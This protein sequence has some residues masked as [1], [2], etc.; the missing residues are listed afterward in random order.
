MILIAQNKVGYK[1]LIQLSSDAATQGFYYRPRV[2]LALLEE[3]S[4]GLIC[5]TACIASQFNQFLLEGNFDNAKNHLADLQNIF[6]D[7]FYLELQNHEIPEQKALVEIALDWGKK[8][9]IP[10]VA[11]NDYH[12]VFPEDAHYQDIIFCDQLKSSLD[13]TT[14]MK[15]NQ[16]FYIKT[17]EEMQE[18]LP[19]EDALDNTIKIAESCELSLSKST[20]A[21]PSF[22]KE[23]ARFDALIRQ[24]ITER[25]ELLPDDIYKQRLHDEV[26]IIKDAKL[27]GYFLTVADYI[28]WA[29]RNDVMVGPGR[30][31]VAG[32]L[33]AYVLHIH[34]VDP[35][36]YGLLFSR[37]YNA[38]RKASLP[39]VD[40]DFAESDVS[41]VVNY[42]VEK[43]GND[44]V[45]HIG[46]FQKIAGR[47]A[48]KMV[49]R[50]NRV[51]FDLANEYSSLVDIKKHK[52]LADAA[53]SIAFQ[54][55]YDTDLQFKQI[56]D[57]AK[58]V[59][60]TA[61]S[62]GVHAA[63]IVI[64]SKPIIETIPIRK[65][66]RTDLQVTAWDMEDV[67]S[68]G[69]VKFDFLS[70]GT[71][72][73]MRNCMELAGITDHYTSLPLDD[74]KA[75]ELISTTSNVGVFQLS[76]TGIS[77]LANSMVVRSID[78][79]ATVVALYRP[80]PLESGLDKSYLDRRFGNKRVEYLHAKCEPALKAT[81]GVL[82]FQ[83]QITR[84][85]MDLASFDEEEADEL[86][87]VIGKKLIEKAG[88]K[89][90]LTRIGSN[91]IKKCGENG[92]D[93]RIAEIIWG[94]INKFAGYA[95]NKAH[96]TS[97]ALLTYYTAY[98]KAHYPVEYM[99][100]LLN[101]AIGKPDKMKNYLTECKRLG[102][103][104]VPPR[105]SHEERFT[106]RDSSILFGLSGIKGLGSSAYKRIKGREYKT[107]LD[108]V[109]R[110]KPETD[111][112]VALIEAGALDGMGYSRKAM[113]NVAEDLMLEVRAYAKKKNPN[114]KALFKTSFQF[115]IPQLAEYSDRELSAMELD[116]L[117]AYIGMNPLDSYK[118]FID[119][120]TM[121]PDA[122]Q[123]PYNESVRIVCIPIR[124][125]TFLTKASQREMCICNTETAGDSVALILFPKAYAHLRDRIKMGTPILV[126][127][128]VV[129]GEKF[130]LAADN[131]DII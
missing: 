34:D 30:G 103:E 13:D 130:S 89:E 40:T 19:Y 59:E 46:T 131:V 31:S 53:E 36:K 119:Q 88:G 42:L 45:A 24:G 115:D 84:L 14:R 95:F 126:S 1:N 78:D 122:T 99:T 15:L 32:S 97:Y 75:Y 114:Q 48:I 38:G 86:R 77:T 81:L 98:L 80:G 54:T 26:K 102:I 108:F 63:G 60:H 87:K 37:F 69:L 66:K 79:I 67:E 18:M 17:R 16:H 55:R 70:L 49:C 41:K 85:V 92:I 76:S 72:D 7:N 57:E 101:S 123:I 64:S 5:T 6:G 73:V 116:R 10:L 106:C 8:H 124:I 47:G 71:L 61:V 22:D 118:E 117:G 91:F 96:A 127:G 56:I 50:V 62:Q 120:H 33:V 112:L 68:A 93:K 11:T 121:I 25:F 39:D 9:D 58:A 94:Q 113:L 43:Y 110:V 44:H 100:A 21:L 4:K 83:E 107:Y 3:H 20:Y 129:M 2:D 12:Y 82:V 74:D 27:I 128:R 104:I 35:I 109:L 51:P 111:T 125:K 65:D 29:K 23:E 90:K 28:Q 52:T 105:H